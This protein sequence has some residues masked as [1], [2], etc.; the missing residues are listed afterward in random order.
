MAGSGDQL[1]YGEL[2]SRSDRVGHLFRSSGL[3]RGDVV[4]ILM[5]NH[6]RFLEVAWGAQ[7]AGLYYTAVNWH[8]AADEI[9]YIVGNCGARVVVTSALMADRLRD[10]EGRLP[11]VERILCVDGELRTN[12]LPNLPLD[13]DTSCNGVDDDCNASTDEDYIPKPVTC[14]QCRAAQSTSCVDG[15]EVTPFEGVPDCKGWDGLLT[16]D[17]A[18]WSVIPKE[19]QVENAHFYARSGEAYVDLGPGTAGSLTWCAGSAYFVR[20][21]QHEGDPAALMR[22]S[23][24]TGL[25]VVYES[26]GGQAFLSEPRCGGDSLTVTALAEDGDEQVTAPLS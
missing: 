7:R 21:P 23:A 5:E 15:E 24:D 3:R 17:G 16:E 4:V 19:H 14:G 6:L 8:L 22:W 1:T 9:A 12:C 13:N 26:P 20:D 11:G 10:L 2:L 18:V 25:A